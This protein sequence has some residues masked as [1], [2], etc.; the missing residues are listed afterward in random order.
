LSKVISMSRVRFVVCIVVVLA[1]ALLGVL[2]RRSLAASPA[3]DG[4]TFSVTIGG[5]FL[6]PEPSLIASSTQPVFA[7]QSFPVV[8]RTADRRWLQL[9]APGAPGW[10]LAAYGVLKGNLSATPVLTASLKP[11]LTRA[12]ASLPRWIPAI[13]PR[14]RQL[15]QQSAKAGRDLSMFTV[16]GD[17]NS[18][19]TAYLGRLAAGTFQLSKGQEYLQ[20]SITRFAAA[21]PRASLATHGSFGAMAMFDGTWADPAQCLPDEGPLACELRVSKASIVFI[22]LGTGDQYAWKDF[23]QNERAV[24]DFVLKAGALPV[25]V[26]KADDLETHSGAPSG[27][28]N[29][30]IRRLGKEYGVPVL[31]FWAATRTLPNYGLRN[32]G[33]D[34]FHMTPAGSDTRILATLQTLAALTGR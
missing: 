27:A 33:N 14:M 1:A 18:E 4:P 17:C 28:I 5:A 11:A 31:D 15:Y 21:F 12:P 23:E 26:T 30:V 24:I 9:N 6:R 16:V 32:E 3:A 10:I 8:G 34:N 19:S 7:N 2:Q 22:A 29:S 13:T 25:L 20:A